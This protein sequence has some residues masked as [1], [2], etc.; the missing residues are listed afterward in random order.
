V[1]NV[2][3]EKLYRVYDQ[4]EAS[5]RGCPATATRSRVP[6]PLA[7]VVQRELMQQRPSVEPGVV[8]IV[9]HEFFSVAPDRLDAIDE[10]ALLAGSTKHYISHR[11]R[12]PVESLRREADGVAIVARAGSI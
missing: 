5:P 11:N 2:S 3:R 12:S 10:H 6:L 4:P 1:R 8:A 7:F 9:E